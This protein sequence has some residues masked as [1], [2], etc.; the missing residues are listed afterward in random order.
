MFGTKIAVGLAVF[1][2][3]SA[4]NA[5][6]HLPN[7]I[8]DLLL[9]DLRTRDVNPPAFIPEAATQNQIKYQPVLDYDTDGCYNVP[10]VD[11]N[12]YVAEGRDHNEG[13][14]PASN[15]R[16]ASDL[17]NQN[18]Y[19][20]TRC[21][22]GWCAYMYEHYFE[23]DVGFQLLWKNFGH[24][25]DWENIV[26]IVRDGE[27]RPA[28]IAA[29][30]H[31][32]YET[33]PGRDVRFDGTHAKIV[34]HKDGASTHAFR[35]ANE[36][37]DRI[38]NHKGHWIRGALID[39]NSFPSREVRD[40]MVNSFNSGGIK[41][42]LADSEFAPNLAKSIDGKADVPGFNVNVDA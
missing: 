25:H 41:I 33:K 20:R 3:L 16:D 23:K 40:K 21:N 36:G 27:E 10:A 29:S 4:V 2:G 18:V 26:V 8:R 12:G 17:D 11:A 14:G 22:S 38:E 6:P 5:L 7:E 13:G 42:K 32:S 9:N 19:V 39:W 28:Y 35:F 30:A 31:G 37:D 24:R 34:Y 1:S 15:C